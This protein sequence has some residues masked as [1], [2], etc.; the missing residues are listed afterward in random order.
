MQ[1]DTKGLRGPV[2]L[3]F[4][5]STVVVME[6]SQRKRVSRQRSCGCNRLAIGI[7]AI[8]IFFAGTAWRC[9]AQSEASSPASTHQSKPKHS[10]KKATH[11][12]K[13]RVAR[14]KS[15]RHISKKERRR[16]LARVRQLRHAFVASS[17]LRP[18]AQQL[19]TLHSP[20]AYAGV[21]RYARAN[22][23][24]AADAAYLALGNAYLT[25]Q[26]YPEA[27]AAFH[28]ARKSGP[29]LAD[30]ADY[31][32]AKA[33]VAQKKYPSA[34][35][36]LESFASRHPDSILIHRAILLL[37]SVDVAE[38]DPQNALQ[39]LAALD[40]TRI[41]NRSDYLFVAA[42]AHQLAGNPD[43]AIRLYKRIYTDYPVS[44]E[45]L[46]V[47]SKLRSMGETTPFSIQ[48]RAQHAAGLAR[49]GKFSDAAAQYLSLAADPASAGTSAQNLY[50]AQATLAAFHQQHHVNAS[51]LARLSDS[52]DDAGQIRLYLMV[53]LARDQ[54]DAVQVKSLLQQLLQ[55]YPQSRW[56]TEALFSAGNMALVANDLP[57]AIQDYGALATHFPNSPLAAASH[58]HAAWLT[59]RTGDKQTAAQLFQDQITNYPDQPQSAAAMYWRGRIYQD[60]EHNNAA[61]V[62]CYNK[63]QTSNHHYYYAHLARKQLVALPDVAAASL[64]FLSHIAMPS[65]PALSIDVPDDD[66]HVIRAKLLA[67]AGLNQYIAPEIQASPDSS[68]WAAYAEAQIYSSYG[69][70]FRSLEVLKSAVH[71]Y[72]SVPIDEIPRN[73]WT[74]LFPQP[75]WP[76]LTK[77]AKANGLDPY[78]VASLIRQE[79]EFNPAVISYANAYGLMQLIPLAGRQMALKAH[80]HS[81]QTSALL[82]PD[83]N[84]K[85]GT[86]YLRQLLDEFNGQ[87]EYALAAYNA[88][89]DRVKSWLINGPYA[90]IPEFVESIPFTQTREYV[91]AILRNADIYRRLY[92]EKNSV[93]AS[94]PTSATS[95]AESQ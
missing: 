46:Q 26:K 82:N 66:E 44:T 41:Q 35:T 65:L 63:L 58:W 5:C 55:R 48:D 72:F 37:A 6:F 45:A 33:D 62:A 7:L 71:S 84:L 40:N 67:N 85:L 12:P 32:E 39:H 74:L 4:G 11:H 81:F 18:M 76:A 51:E 86:V 56:T 94:A 17:Q 61:A 50:L 21:E 60:V 93:A 70:T 9:N 29:A 89:D 64:P 30:Y 52:N 47:E 23:G 77:N 53:E 49:A 57:T 27:T 20:E 73:Y 91:Q 24:E 59:Y 19:Q 8:F 43:L 75:Y 15:K 36:L 14:A 16:N 1:K 25:D 90:D 88:G 69:E 2:F 68:E 10:R 95:F 31:L 42:Q 78:L 13:R 92:E 80:V 38:G 3:W 28:Q 34:Q 83:V 54:S 87:T 22:H 79:S